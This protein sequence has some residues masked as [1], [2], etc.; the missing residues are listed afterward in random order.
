MHL[1]EKINSRGIELI[2]YLIVLIYKEGSMDKLKL[3]IET[4]FSSLKEAAVGVIVILMMAF[5]LFAVIMT[6]LGKFKKKKPDLDVVKI[7]KPIIKYTTSSLTHTIKAGNKLI[8]DTIAERRDKGK[9]VGTH[10]DYYFKKTKK[11]VS[12]EKELDEVRSR[13]KA[14]REEYIRRDTGIDKSDFF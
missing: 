14:K 9:V 12:L 4:T 13:E 6:I 11:E 2:L 5:L 10:T 7:V 1:P 8:S 3:T